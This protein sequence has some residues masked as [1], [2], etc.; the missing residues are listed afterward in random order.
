MKKIAYIDMDDVMVNYQ[1]GIDSLDEKN[2]QEY[3]G[4]LDNVPGLFALMDPLTG[5]IK[6]TGKLSSL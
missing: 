6:L 5:A 4:N 3:E 1:S 2:K